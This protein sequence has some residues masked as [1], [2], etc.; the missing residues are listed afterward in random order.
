MTTPA[1]LISL[2]KKTR[3]KGVCVLALLLL[4]VGCTTDGG[5]A[6][7]TNIADTGSR[8][9]LV[10]E[11]SH[12]QVVRSPVRIKPVEVSQADYNA[13]MVRLARELRDKLPPRPEKQLE[14][15]SW[16]SPEQQDEHSQLVAAYY[17]WCDSRGTPGD[18]FRLLKGLPYL[19]E[20]ARRALAFALANPGVWDGT[21]AVINEVLDPVQLQIAVMSTLTMTLTLLAIP[22][23]ISKVIVIVITAS[24][25]GY[26]GWDTLAGLIA[27]WRQLEEEAHILARPHTGGMAIWGGG[28]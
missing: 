8:V 16:G 24:L 10:T 7:G 4:S 9:V 13:A 14:I 11:E 3:M 5:R 23:P 20:E 6:A 17:Q 25:I 21:A 28:Y 26:V 18:C 12:A 1:T 27:G 19:T 2:Q 22:E 15:V